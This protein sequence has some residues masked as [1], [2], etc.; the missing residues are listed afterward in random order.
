MAVNFLMGCKLTM[1]TL[2][3]CIWL[4]FGMLCTAFN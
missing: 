2:D 4:F 3:A 1:V